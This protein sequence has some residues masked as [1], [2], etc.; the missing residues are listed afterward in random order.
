MYAHFQHAAEGGQGSSG[1]NDQSR[2]TKRSRRLP[3]EDREIGRKKAD[4]ADRIKLDRDSDIRKRDRENIA[5]RSD[6]GRRPKDEYDLPPEGRDMDF[7][8]KRYMV[9]DERLDR[10]GNRGSKKRGRSIVEK[11]HVE[12]L[13]DEGALHSI[14]QSSDKAYILK[15]RLAKAGSRVTTEQIADIESD[16]EEYMQLERVVA[17]NRQ[18]T[19][20]MY[21]DAKEIDD[22]DERRSYL[23]GLKETK[24]ERKVKDKAARDV[25]REKYL[26]IK[27]KVDALLNH[28]EL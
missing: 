24:E 11:H 2:K 5:A 10:R 21:H 20:K 8:R 16:L 22:K 3:D 6:L 26:S 23:D 14:Q 25:A 19:T 13:V 28:G 1:P 27:A 17:F 15:N 12:G 7:D 9:G 4:R 18:D